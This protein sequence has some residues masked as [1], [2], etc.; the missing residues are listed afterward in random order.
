MIL[1]LFVLRC[2]M[3][4]YFVTLRSNVAQT[5][6]EKIVAS[7]SNASKQIIIIK[8]LVAKLCRTMLGDL[9]TLAIN[10]HTNHTLLNKLWSES[11]QSLSLW[12]PPF[13]LFMPI[14]H[15]HSFNNISY[16]FHDD[17]NDDSLCVGGDEGLWC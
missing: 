12:H 16:T 15:I 11:R 3:I 1:S 9:K 13:P 8:S 4:L 2:N 10:H 6:F 5:S 14:S 17:S 7:D